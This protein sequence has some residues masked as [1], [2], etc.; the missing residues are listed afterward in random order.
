MLRGSQI[1]RRITAVLVAA[2]AVPSSAGAA[3]PKH[4]T[5]VLRPRDSAALAAYAR[6]VS[7]PAS[8]SFH[9][10]LT[11][12]QFG[13]RFGAS[14]TAVRAA[15]RALL[16][17]GFSPGALSVNRLSITA[18][19]SDRGTPA[20]LAVL[21]RGVLHERGGAIQTM[22]GLGNTPGP[23][24]LSVRPTRRSTPLA[25]TAQAHPNTGGPKPCGAARNAAAAEGAHTAD[26]IASAYGFSGIY[27][28]HN[29]GAGVT[30]AVYELE[31]VALSD[32]AAYQSCYGITAPI[33]F[34]HVDGGSGS[35]VGSGEA[36]L[37]IENATSYAPQARL[38]VYQGPNSNSGAPGSGPYDTFSAIVNQD[39]AQ[40]VSVSWGECEAALGPA[41]AA[42]ENALFEQAA[43]QGQTVVAAAGDSGSE[44]CEA[45]SSVPQPQLAVDDPASQ[46][47]VTGVGG[48]TLELLG[49][50]P[51]EK[52]WNSGGTPAA[53]LSPG[54]AGGGVSTLWGMPLTQQNAA[55]WLNVHGAG[56]NG[57]HCGHPGGY[58]RE[59]PDVSA[60]ADPATGY[61]IY[62]NGS[63]DVPGATR[64]WQAIGGTSAAAPL[65][66]GVMA[67]ADA[68]RTCAGG[69]VGMALPAL[70]RAAGANYSGDF[71]DVRTGNND[72]TSMNGGQFTAGPGYDEA[73]GL[74]TP[75]ASALVPQLCTSALL[76]R[77][78]PAQ[79]SARLA[80]LAGFRL[81]LSD[82]PRASSTVRVRGLPSG[83][84]F[85]AVTGRIGGNPRRLGRYAVT[86]TAT[87]ADGARARQRFV[88][89]IAG[90][91]HLVAP[92]VVGLAQGRPVLR[93]TV[94]AGQGAP[95]LRRLA[96]S[97]PGELRLRSTRSIAVNASG[98][99]VGFAAHIDHGLLI[100]TLHRGYMRVRVTLG[101][102][103]IAQARGRGPR[104]DRMRV[105]AVASDRSSSF[106]QAKVGNR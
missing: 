9:R 21:A 37:D 77:P 35:G 15:R 23:R 76:L 94:A 98:G 106:L 17:R 56:A 49:P 40:V 16:V 87:D 54:A 85:R 6:A 28:G 86:V 89:T 12:A 38:L 7:D 100:I 65:W 66:A 71:N 43:V 33:N 74:G 20:S 73:S 99:R 103:A 4:L 32:L 52:V 11:P 95:S 97:L 8:T 53:L 88:W 67:L 31:P 34:V 59:V 14:P 104:V 46:P 50:R 26:Q 2:L 75:N 3:I 68:N 79:H 70:Y 44:D 18:S 63:G 60:N 47:F 24:P 90:A 27:G 69:S 96:V 78:V 5:A 101:P 1:T 58:C 10:F 39:R 64:G 19:A 55:S 102:R 41:S 51:A 80:R 25:T 42:A 82:V 81:P 72:F 30:I 22:E 91:T 48:T 105:T 62:W 13:R 93:F 92:S 84:R 45:S 83:L 29:L 36:A 57:A 61:E